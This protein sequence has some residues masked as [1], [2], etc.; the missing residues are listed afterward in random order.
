MKLISYICGIVVLLTL[1]AIAWK[2]W[3]TRTAIIRKGEW[4]TDTSATEISCSFAIS[5]LAPYRS[6]ALPELDGLAAIA[7]DVVPIKGH[8]H[9]RLATSN[10]T[11]ELRDGTSTRLKAIR[12]MHFNADQQAM[13]A[14]GAVAEMIDGTSR[15]GDISVNYGFV[16]FGF[17]D[18][19]SALI[20]DADG[21]ETIT[22]GVILDAPITNVKTITFFGKT[23]IN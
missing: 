2:V 20:L 22:L 7:I 12:P 17:I 11:A 3:V 14:S 6:E 13:Q 18:E 1:S 10:V 15:I 5:Q 19:S 16:T 8:L 4:V 23:L 9:L 21:A